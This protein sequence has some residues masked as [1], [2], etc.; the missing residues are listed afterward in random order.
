ME[1]LVN[2]KVVMVTG[3]GGIG[4][5]L[6]AACLGQYAASLGKRTIIIEST[7]R[8]QLI[9]LF[10]ARENDDGPTQIS[11]NLRVQN[12][13]AD[14]NLR[15]YVT[16]YLGQQKLYDK[17]FNNK[18]VSSFLNNIPALYEAMLLGRIHYCSKLA[19]D[20]DDLVIFDGPASGH[21]Y[22]LILTPEALESTKIGGPIAFETKRI[23]DFLSRPENCGITYVAVPEELVISECMD[24]IPKLVKDTPINVSHI[25]MNKTINHW[26]NTPDTHG[27]EDYFENRRKRNQLAMQEFEKGMQ[28]LKDDLNIEIPVLQ[29]RDIGFNEEPLPT[30]QFKKVFSGLI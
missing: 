2:K 6:F 29:T 8:S 15:D 11:Q 17:V 10:G 16:K 4:K 5:T 22:R 23:I 25:V 14:T 21:F 13:T 9:P 30:D 26:N 18:V 28:S 3:K 27:F 12:C 20:S 7:V 19:P 24:F 1:S